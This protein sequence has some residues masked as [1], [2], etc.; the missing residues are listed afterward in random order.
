MVLLC[1]AL[2]CLAHVAISLARNEGICPHASPAA[3]QRRVFRP[4]DLFPNLKL[5]VTLVLA[6]A[7]ASTG[8]EGLLASLLEENL[9][10]TELNALANS[11]TPGAL[12]HHY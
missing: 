12:L 2:S 11:P 4:I 1:C 8:G 10:D 3:V 9:D 7:A 6:S 5:F